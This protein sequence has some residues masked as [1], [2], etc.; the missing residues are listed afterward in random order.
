MIHCQTFGMMVAEVVVI[1]VIEAGVIARFAA[2]SL[3]REVELEAEVVRVE[4]AGLVSSSLPGNL[5]LPAVLL[6][7]QPATAHNS[8]HRQSAREK[9]YAPSRPLVG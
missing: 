8:Y 9:R 7:Q 4:E 2:T 6:V 3:P 1:V 5:Y